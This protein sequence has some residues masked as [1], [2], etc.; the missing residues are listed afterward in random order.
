MS[1]RTKP[2]EGFQDGVVEYAH[3]RGWR[4]A[5]FR[6]AWSARGY[7]TPVQYDGDGFPDLV[8]CRS[9]RLV[10]AELK[11]GAAV[12]AKQRAWLDLLGEV[13]GVDVYLWTPGDWPEIERVLA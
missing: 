5:H 2:E 12:S 1:D 13:P 9:P 10:I 3:L 4:A 6:H 7:R 11:V 8:L